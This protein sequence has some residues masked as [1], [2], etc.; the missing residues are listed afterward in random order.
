MTLRQTDGQTR[1]RGGRERERV[2]LR[3]RDAGRTQR[4]FSNFVGKLRKHI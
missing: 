3:L 1:R 4:T 2:R